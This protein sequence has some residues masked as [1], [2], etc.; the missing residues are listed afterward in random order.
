MDYPQL[1][2]LF[3]LCLILTVVVNIGL[4]IL[5]SKLR[6]PVWWFSL[7]WF[8]L[9]VSIASALYIEYLFLQRMAPAFNRQIGFGWLLIGGVGTLVTAI[10]YRRVRYSHLV[11]VMFVTQMLVSVV[12]LVLAFGLYRSLVP[13]SPP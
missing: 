5:L 2:F 12:S 4:H 8:A 3:G 9:V 13:V 10:L 7:S 11:S 1:N 6:L